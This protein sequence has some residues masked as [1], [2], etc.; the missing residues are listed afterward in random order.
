M[1]IF[2]PTN[3]A[4]ASG[5]IIRESLIAL[6]NEMV[7]YV[8]GPM[9]AKEFLDFLPCNP[10]KVR[11]KLFAGLATQKEA[12]MYTPFVRVSSFFSVHNCIENIFPDQGDGSFLS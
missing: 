1:S 10:W 9:P 5:H 8:V 7:G 2:Y 6:G 11:K 12:A 4:F 3:I